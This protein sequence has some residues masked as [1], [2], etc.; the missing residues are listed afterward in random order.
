MTHE[1]KLN[2][3][4]CVVNRLQNLFFFGL[5]LFSAS[6]G[7]ALDW[8][9]SKNFLREKNYDYSYAVDQLEQA[10]LTEKENLSL[11]LPQIDYILKHEQSNDTL[12]VYERYYSSGLVLTQNL[13]NG[14]KDYYSYKSNQ[15][16]LSLEQ[17]NFKLA[18]I[19]LQSELKR[20]VAQ[21][22]YTQKSVALSESIVVRRKEN[23]ESVSLRYGTGYE[24]KAAVM[25][26]EAYLVDSN[27]DIDVSKADYD[28]A[29]K[30][31]KQFLGINQ[32]EKLIW[33]GTIPQKNITVLDDHTNIKFEEILK[34][35]STEHPLILQAQHE[36]R[37]KYFDHQVEQSG[38]F[39]MLDLTAKYTDYDSQP[40]LQQSK[41]LVGLTLTIPLF[42]GFSTVTKNKSAELSYQQALKKTLNQT[43]F[44]VNQIHKSFANL[45]LAKTR[46]F[47]AEK[48]LKAAKL[49]AEYM[50][51]KYN[52][53][54]AWFD[55]WDSAETSLIAREK[56]Y[57][58]SQRDL[59]VALADFEEAIAYDEEE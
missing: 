38:F 11:F 17:L 4:G 39:P 22:E 24:D 58:Q 1:F 59:I 12:D 44:V 9:N 32:G 43:S 56:D 55:R 46:V 5:F 50:H 45:K 10:R 7:S 54:L 57:L 26:S 28:Q 40:Q 31:L 51:E 37:V 6:S 33:Q 42:S 3:I 15:Q 23:F 18:K 47:V 2:V 29:D 13:F 34:K 19:K 36:E 52:L 41:W 53:G 49:R 48:Y 16:K 14:G 27:L 25:L 30:A 20:L 21:L 8:Q 35:C